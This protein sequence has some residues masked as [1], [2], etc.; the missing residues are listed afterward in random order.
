[1]LKPRTLSKGGS[2]VD[3]NY[4]FFGGASIYAQAQSTS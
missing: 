1:V 2:S 4:I 3:L